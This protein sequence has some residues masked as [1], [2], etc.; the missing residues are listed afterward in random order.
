LDARI[1]TVENTSDDPWYYFA[2]D[3]RWRVVGD[4]RGTDTYCKRQYVYPAAGQAGFGGSSSIDLVVLRDRDATASWAGSMTTATVDSYAAP[5]TGGRGVQSR[6]LAARRAG[7]S[8]SQWDPV[9]KQN[10]V[11][12]RVYNPKMGRRASAEYHVWRLIA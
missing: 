3:E 10:H 7:N 1:R 2:Y 12:H 9:I 11:T 5:N 8:G 6:S 4:F